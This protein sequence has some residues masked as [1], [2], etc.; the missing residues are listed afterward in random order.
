MSSKIPNL[1]PSQMPITLMLWNVQ[2]AGSRAFLA[3]LKELIRVH[4]PVVIALVEG[5]GDQAQFIADQINFSG[6]TR[7]DAQGFAGGIW[8]YW[9][10][11][12]VTVHETEN[13]TQHITMQITR[14]GEEPWYFTAIY[15]SPN[16]IKRQELWRSLKT[17]AENNNHPWHQIQLRKELLWRRSSKKGE[18]VR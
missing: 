18:E 6:Q 14:V 7:V 5:G 10:A 1:N 4:K 17:Y 16:L 8:V 2:G 11:D 15:A 13:S 3:D 12:L 9:K